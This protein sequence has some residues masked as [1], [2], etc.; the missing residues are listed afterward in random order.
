MQFLSA[1]DEEELAPENPITKAKTIK[2][3]PVMVI[4]LESLSEPRE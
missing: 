3:I 4:F 2:A 1:S